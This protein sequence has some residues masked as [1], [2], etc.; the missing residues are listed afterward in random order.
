MYLI[1]T[2]L[3][4]LFPAALMAQTFP[5]EAGSGKIVYTEEVLV[6]DADHTDLFKRAYNWLT[7]Q[8][9][10][11]TSIKTED[12]SNGVL[13]ANNYLDLQVKD[14]SLKS[15]CMVLYT[16]QIKVDDD[17]YWYRFSDFILEERKGT[18][19]KI[20]VK[21]LPLEN[22]LHLPGKNQQV[23][24]GTLNKTLS[25]EILAARLQELINQFK[26]SMLN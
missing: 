14:K 17:R 20:S 7:S 8:K 1:H 18:T 10:I 16:I 22:W 9:K 23:T 12:R 24:S 6:K 3:I 11:S 4:L 19:P 21:K 15:S 13:V 26:A 2:F 25:K 5:V